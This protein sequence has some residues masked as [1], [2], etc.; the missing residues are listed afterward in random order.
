MSSGKA[1]TLAPAL[2]DIEMAYFAFA[3]LSCNFFTFSYI[4]FFIGIE[5]RTHNN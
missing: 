3:K 2:R 4:F 5:N 1:Y